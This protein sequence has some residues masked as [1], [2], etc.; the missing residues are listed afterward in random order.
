MNLSIRISAV[1][2]LLVLTYVSATAVVSAQEPPA[3]PT[4]MPAVQNPT[5]LDVEYDGRTHITLAPY[6]WAPTV[7]GNFQFSIPNLPRRAGGLAQASAQVGPSDYLA[8]LNSAAMFAFDAR[9]GYV[10]LFGDLI[11]VNASVSAS[12]STTL[13]GR[14]GRLAIPASIST[15]AHLRQSIWEAAAGFTVARGHD[16]DLSLF[17]GIREFPLRLSF[18]YTATIGRRRMFTRSGSIVTADIAQDVIFG[19]R[20]KAFFGGSHFFVPYYA[21]VGSGIGQLNNQTWQLYSGAGYAFNHGQTLL[22][23]YRA[24]TYEGFAPIS[25]VQRLSMHGPLLGYTFNL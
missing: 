9:K 4:P 7:G 22:V 21:D 5:P 2:A 11:Y 19:L 17:T 8:K 6:I 16:A 15:N 12:A 14:F 13:S 25:H 10:D 20:G 24:L 18:D 1:A 23:A 3:S